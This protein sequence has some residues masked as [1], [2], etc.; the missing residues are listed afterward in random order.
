MKATIKRRC[1]WVLVNSALVWLAYAAV[2]GN[3]G[4]GRLLLFSLW[5]SATC[6]WLALLHQNPPLQLPRSVPAQLSHG[7][8]IAMTMFLVGH[9]WWLTAVAYVLQS[10][11]SEV[12]FHPTS[13][14]K[15]S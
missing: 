7:F 3:P 2:Q 10:L 12:M 1:N 6:H 4:A 11:A 15:E 9:G 8:D 14:P 5:L 13:R